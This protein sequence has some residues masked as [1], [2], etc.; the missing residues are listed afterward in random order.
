MGNQLNVLA[1]GAIGSF[2]SKQNNVLVHGK[3]MFLL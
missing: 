1:A 3:L 2:V